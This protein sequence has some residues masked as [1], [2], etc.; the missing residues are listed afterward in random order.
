MPGRS[1]ASRPS[2]GAGMEIVLGVRCIAGGKEGVARYVGETQFSQGQWVG[3]ELD[4]PL[5]K[6]DGTVA[7]VKYFMAAPNHGLFVKRSLARLAPARTALGKGLLATTAESAADDDGE[8]GEEG[9]RR[10]TTALGK[11]GAA[12]VRAQLRSGGLAALSAFK[13]GAAIAVGTRVSG[14]GKEGVARFVGETQFAP[15]QWVGIELDAATGKNNGTVKGVAY[16]ACAANRGLFVKRSLVRLVAG[17]AA[18]GAGAADAGATAAA[19]EAGGAAAAEPPAAAPAAAAVAVEPDAEPTATG[20]DAGA[21]AV[22][23]AVAV[24][25]V[26]AQLDAGAAASAEPQAP[27]SPPPAEATGTGSSSAVLDRALEK[28]R[29]GAPWVG[30]IGKGIDDAAAA[31]LAEELRFNATL[32]KM[33]LT[34]NQ[35]GDAGAAQL[36]DAL[37]ANTNTALTWV[38]LGGNLMGD[39]ARQAVLAIVAKNKNDPVKSQ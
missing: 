15:G 23:V 2:Y 18:T 22:V 1:P 32:T 33:W 34:D 37:R 13:S 19:V 36:A 16:F 28:M 17:A 35:I 7:G 30:L 5:G 27:A 39:D 38:A 31:R 10:L 25:A 6:N 3:I 29:G 14:G 20:E 26:E 11:D 21:A 8:D 4:A 24:P 9:T 12:L